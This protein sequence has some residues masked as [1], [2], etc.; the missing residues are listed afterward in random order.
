LIL[1]ENSEMSNR[2]DLT[3]GEQDRMA[4][5]GSVDEFIAERRREA[6]KAASASPSVAV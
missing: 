4:G 6:Y 1:W 3:L 2:F 5:L